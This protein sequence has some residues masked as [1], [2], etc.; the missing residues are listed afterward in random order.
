[1]RMR[2]L[3][4]IRATSKV[5][6]DCEFRDHSQ[7]NNERPLSDHFHFRDVGVRFQP[8]PLLNPVL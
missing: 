5:A 8:Q 3:W 4:R 7:F 1:M 2:F 6:F